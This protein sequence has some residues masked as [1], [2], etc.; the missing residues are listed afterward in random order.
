M[1]MY[2]SCERFWTMSAPDLAGLL[3]RYVTFVRATGVGPGSPAAAVTEILAFTDTVVAPPP[4]PCAFPWRTGGSPRAR[5]TSD[6]TGGTLVLTAGA[7]ETRSPVP[8]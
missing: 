8:S 5:G 3:T 1:H 2:E 4:P 6:G 7:S